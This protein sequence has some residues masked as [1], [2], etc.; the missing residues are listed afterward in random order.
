MPDQPQNV[1][2]L[3]F[4][5]KISWEGQANGLPPEI[6]TYIFYRADI[7]TEEVTRM[8][9]TQFAVYRQLGGMPVEKDQGQIIDTRRTI[10]DRIL[11]KDRW[12]VSIHPDIV[13][14]PGETPLADDEGVERLPN[15]Q[16][17]LKN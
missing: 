11:V 13:P 16:P 4:T 6:F 7:P 1:R 12:I 8:I 17:A 9:E 3:R 10:M 15:G 14:I 5:G 2:I